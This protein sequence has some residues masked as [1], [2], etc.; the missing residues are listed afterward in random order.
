[1]RSRYFVLALGMGLSIGLGGL[2]HSTP[3][4]GLESTALHT[5]PPGYH[6]MGPCASDLGHAHQQVQQQGVTT[7]ILFY[8]GSELTA[9]VYVL[10]EHDVTDGK[11]WSLLSELGGLPV[12]SISFSYSQVNPFKN[13]QRGSYYIMW[14]RLERGPSTSA[15]PC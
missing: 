6:Q 12:A 5:P 14:L 4:F 7:P 1:M 8:S 10:D 9:V 15:V 2:V 3:V 11:S 13:K